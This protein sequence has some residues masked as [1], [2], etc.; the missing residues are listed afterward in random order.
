MLAYNNGQAEF[1]YKKENNKKLKRV[2]DIKSILFDSSYQND[3]IAKNFLSLNS[4][5]KIA[6][7]SDNELENQ[8]EILKKS[9]FHS[10][11]VLIL[12]KFKGRIFQKCPGSPEMICCNYYLLNTCFDCLYDCVYCFLNFYK[13]SFGITQFL[14]GDNIA[15]EMNNLFHDENKIYRVGTG[16]F[17]DSLMF[18]E[19]TGIGKMLIEKASEHENI[20]LE[21]KTKSDNIS[22]LLEIKN[23]GNAVIAWSINTEKN[24]ELYEN[25][26]AGLTDRIN[27]AKLCA[28]AGFNIAFHFDPIIIGYNYIEDYLDTV[29]LLMES[30]D[31]KKIAWISMGCFRHVPVMKNIIQ[32]KFPDEKLSIEEMFPGMDGKLRYLKKIRVE[33]YRRLKEKIDSYPHKA[34]IYL[35]ME[36]S[37]VWYDSFQ[38]NYSSPEELEIAISDHMRNL[39]LKSHC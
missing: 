17:T 30:V 20:M 22:H 21:L 9:G 27:A 1:E 23:K 11:E 7:S 3:K 25:G 26:T 35:C 8:L 14:C 12:K 13:N 31:I 6:F 28:D 19:I 32:E 2:K 33:T 10:K 16:E 5:E 29:N 36:T 4:A 15:L 24:I 37:D 39:F 18:D 34:F 38:V